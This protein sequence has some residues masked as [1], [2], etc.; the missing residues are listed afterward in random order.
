MRSPFLLWEVLINNTYSGKYLNEVQ[1]L[2]A[3][4]GFELRYKNTADSRNLNDSITSESEERKKRW[5]V[6]AAR[7]YSGKIAELSLTYEP[8]P[9][10]RAAEEARLAAESKAAEESR[11]KAES[12][13][14]ERSKA[15]EESKAK[16]AEESRAAAES[17]AK[18]EEESKAAEE[19][20]AKE[21]QARRAEIEEKVVLPESNSKLGRNFDSEGRST[22]Y[23]INVDDIKNKPVKKKWKSVTVTDGVAEYLNRLENLG[24]KGSIT[25]LVG[26]RIPDIVSSAH[27]KQLQEEVFIIRISISLSAKSLDL[28]VDAFDFRR[29]YIIGGVS[30]DPF[31][32]I[33]Q[34]PLE[35]EQMGIAGC[36]AHV[37]DTDDILRHGALVRPRIGQRQFL[38]DQVKSKEELI[39]PEQLI[40][41][42]FVSGSAHDILCFKQTAPLVD[43]ALLRGIGVLLLKR[44]PGGRQNILC[45]LQC[46]GS[47][48]VAFL[49]KAAL[50][51]LTH[52]AYY[53][54]VEVLDDM[55]V[56][57]YWLDMGALF[58]KRLLEIG[59]HVAGDGFDMVYPLQTDMLYE[60]VHDLLLL[61]SGDPE[62]MPGLHVDDVSGIPVPVVELEFINAKEF[63]MLCRLDQLSVRCSI[64][65]LKTSLINRLYDVLTEAGK[66]CDLL[67]CVSPASQQIADI[68][69]QFHRDPVPGRFKRNVLH[70]GIAA[71]G[72]YIL[73]SGE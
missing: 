48:D 42:L 37:H 10:E 53:L 21:E 20:K 15:E 34:Q 12:E 32:M 55:E 13:A 65:L 73:R 11:A 66:L 24:Y 54:I 43:H 16:A 59:I 5:K 56:I 4:E 67:V 9:E 7:Q 40:I 39:L 30:N 35:P 1:K 46:P 68:L 23:Y 26:F 64:K 31:K 45:F 44:L 28:V 19:S 14:A 18:A 71:L 58:L 62:D 60:V 72:T 29:G 69:I 49:I 47:F 38:F 17:N 57:E 33:A 36:M 70:P 8:T 22:W 2:A 50:F 63:R 27:V 51:V 52:F 6:D 61:A 25:K 41:A 3:D